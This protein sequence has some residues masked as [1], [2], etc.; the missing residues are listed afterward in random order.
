MRKAQF[1]GISP[2]ARSYPKRRLLRLE[3]LESRTVFDAAIAAEIFRP[4]I[5]HPVFAPDTPAE[6]MA[7]Y[8]DLQDQGPRI[9]AFSFSDSNRW[10]RTATEIGLAQGDATTITWSI[11]PDGSPISGFN[12]EPA[13]PNNLRSYLAGIYGTNASSTRAEDQPW[14]S[15]FQQVFERWSALSGV[16]YVYEP[17]DDGAS[18]G[19]SASGIRGVRGD[20]RIGG[21][22]IDGTNNILAYNFYPT[23]GDMILDTGDSFFASTGSNSLRLR[24]TVAHEA[25]HGLGLGHVTP[26]NGTKLMEPS[27]S[28]GFDGPQADDILA[29]NRGYGDRLEKGGGN[30]TATSATNLGAPAGAF[31]VDTVSIDDDSD[32]DWFRFTVGGPGQLSITLSPTGS[33]YTSNSTTFNSLAQSN[34]G[35]AVYDGSGSTV[36]ASA[37]LNPAG[38]GE[39]LTGIALSGTGTYF[40]RISGSANAA[41]MYRLSG[42]V[43]TVTSLAPEIQVL[44]GTTDIADNTGN[45]NLGSTTVGSALSRTFTI[46]N[47]GGADLVIGSTI[48]LPAGYTLAQPWSGATIAPGGAAT[49][50]LAVNTATAGTFAGS[51]SLTTN[52]SDEN[53]FNFSITTTV[54]TVPTPPPTS[55]LPFADDFNRTSSTVLGPAWTE[56]VGDL[57]VSAGGLRSN[58]STVSLATVN[59][60]NQA[61]VVLAADMNLGTGTA[62]RSMGLVARYSGT[63]DG[64]W[65]LANLRMTGGRYRVEIWKQLGGVQSLL[66]WSYVSSGLG[67]LRFEVVGSSLKAFWNGTLVAAAADAQLSSGGIGVRSNFVSGVR[68]DNFS[69]SAPIGSLQ[70]VTA[71]APGGNFTYRPNDPAHR[72]PEMEMLYWQ[73]DQAAEIRGR[74]LAMIAAELD[75]WDLL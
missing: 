4:D 8:E 58:T 38:L 70:T 56:R 46:R 45:M 68:L 16:T 34:L 72:S 5:V 26:T 57:A 55:G 48:L 52:D 7:A 43:S 14:F 73:V 64:N 12:G 18:F 40:V 30:D 22:W 21:H 47:Q 37:N 11:A 2:K 65:Y 75:R 20:V 63:G 6:I 25:G 66:S 35:L 36:I 44:D 59:G 41:Q 1:V 39:T 74:L 27:I 24:N 23:V 42:S 51:V 50:T 71:D 31:S 19:S 10:S 13:A 69:A 28:L 62:V 15:V 9:D 53:P 33:T 61:N 17:A 32:V 3:N 54:T 29:V 49:F 67:N 60:V